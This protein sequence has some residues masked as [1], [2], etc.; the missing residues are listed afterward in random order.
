RARSREPDLRARRPRRGELER[1]LGTPE[2]R[3]RRA[4][5]LDACPL[6]RDAP[7]GHADRASAGRARHARPAHDA[8]ARRQR[9]HRPERCRDVPARARAAR[10]AAAARDVTR[11]VV[12]AEADAAAAVEE[13]TVEPPGAREVLVRVLACG[14]CHSDLHVV[15]T[16]GWGM[17]F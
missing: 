6:R 7:P 17:R 3:A 10:R 8:R 13:L 2:A 15:E 16:N 12:Y 9:R 4:A 14:L 11:G 5:A 1:V